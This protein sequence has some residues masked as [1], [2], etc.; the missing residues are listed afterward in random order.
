[1]ISNVLFIAGFFVLLVAPI[2]WMVLAWSDRP[3]ATPRPTACA[4]TAS[5]CPRGPRGGFPACGRPVSC[6]SRL[7]LTSSEL[8]AVVV[9]IVHRAIML[10]TGVSSSPPAPSLSPNP[11]RRCARP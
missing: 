1:M 6:I 9:A 8:G 3:R 2:E 4:Q 5:C 7:L 11:D 10:L